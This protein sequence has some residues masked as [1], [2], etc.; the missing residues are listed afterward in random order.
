[1]SNFLK[2]L[3]IVLLVLV[4]LC[5]SFGLYLFI[6]ND[7]SFSFLSSKVEL[8]ESKEFD[9][10]KDLNIDTDTADIYIKTSENN[11][12]KV[13]LYSNDV[14]EKEISNSDTSLNVTLKNDCWFLCFFSRSK[15][16]V[17]LPKNYQNNIVINSTT[18][19]IT[20]DDYALSN[21]DLH[22]TTGDIT[23]KDVKNASIKVT[24][25]DVKIDNVNDV[26]IESTTGDINIKKVN[27]SMN[28]QTTTGDIDI[29]EANLKVNSY[30]KA[31]TGDVTVKKTNDI[32]VESETSTGDNHINNNNRRSE[33]E[34]KIK[35]STGDVNIN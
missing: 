20:M 10:I 2:V 22:V 3:L 24:T 29:Y 4:V 1:M 34:L 13:E 25:G 32:Y 21:V 33:I 5:L 14:K 12:V 8:V 16:Y 28:I 30:L 7:Y 27:N 6:K 26:N 9:S 17:Y 18:G 31:T 11:K 35:T 19:D 23:L 15:I